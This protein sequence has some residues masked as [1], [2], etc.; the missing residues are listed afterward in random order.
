M[1]MFHHVC[2]NHAKVRWKFIHQTTWLI[3]WP[4]TAQRYSI[5][6][7]G[8]FRNQSK[9]ISL[10]SHAVIRA[11][12][13]KSQHLCCSM[14]VMREEVTGS[15]AAMSS[16]LQPTVHIFCPYCTALSSPGFTFT[17]LPVTTVWNS[18]AKS[19]NEACWF[20]TVGLV[21]TLWKN[22]FINR[23]MTYCIWINTLIEVH[24][25]TRA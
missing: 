3:S 22:S 15:C 9:L 20:G 14:S 8:G 4:H 6:V 13:P 18:E 25:I 21:L 16:T 11:N 23:D 7:S 17:V 5:N 12:K 1:N 2:L 24:V 10:C 19:L